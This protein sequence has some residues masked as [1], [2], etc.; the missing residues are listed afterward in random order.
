MIKHIVTW[1]IRG[2]TPEKK[3][4]GLPFLKDRFEGL[5][6]KIPGLLHL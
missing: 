1:N 3:H 6:G 5:I 2:V 4:E